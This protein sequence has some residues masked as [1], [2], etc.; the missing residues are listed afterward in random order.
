MTKRVKIDGLTA[1][2]HKAYK[3]LCRVHGGDKAAALSIFRSGLF[4][5]AVKI[6][7]EPIVV[8]PTEELLGGE[9]DLD[10]DGGDI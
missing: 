3:A 1:Q 5:E 4:V 10:D 8:L 7:S 6:P 9:E 2:E